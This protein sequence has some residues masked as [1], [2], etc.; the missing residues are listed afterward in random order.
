MKNSIIV[1]RFSFTAC[2]LSDAL[3]A[4][5]LTTLSIVFMALSGRG[6]LKI[7]T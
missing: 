1:Y 3:R 5:S 7:L 2:V 4:G 6:F